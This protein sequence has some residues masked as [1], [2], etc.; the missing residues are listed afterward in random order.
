VIERQKQIAQACF[1]NMIPQRPPGNWTA[2]DVASRPSPNHV[3]TIGFVIS[4]QALADHSISSANP[5]AKQSRWPLKAAGE[6]LLKT[7]CDVLPMRYSPQDDDSAVE[8]IF[9]KGDSI[10]YPGYGAGNVLEDCVLSPEICQK[11]DWRG[12]VVKFGRISIRLKFQALDLRR[13]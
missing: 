1:G 4:P 9:K 12:I 5:A 7:A 2:E 11:M 10:M 3:R 13:T 8:R 6:M